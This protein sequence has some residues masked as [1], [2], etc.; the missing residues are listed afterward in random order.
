MATQIKVFSPEHDSRL[1]PNLHAISARPRPDFPFAPRAYKCR[2][3]SAVFFGNSQCLA[4]NSTLGFDPY[5][6][7]LYALERGSSAGLWTIA[8][9]TDEKDYY[10]CAN[11]NTPASCNWLISQTSMVGNP[12]QLCVACRLSRTIPDLSI[13]GNAAL[14]GRIEMAKRRLVSSLLALGLPVASSVDEDSRRGLAFDLL[15]SLPESPHVMTGYANGLIT[16]NIEEA[17]DASRE[18][19]RQQMR[20]PYRTLLGHLRHEVGHYY[21]ERLVAGTP[22]LD[23]FRQL[24]GDERQNYASA[25]RRNYAEGP[26]S[27]WPQHYVS[28]YASTH[29]WEDWAETWAHYLHMSDTLGTALSL[30]IDTS[31]L[32]PDITPFTRE[33]LFRPQAA[34]AAQFLSFLNAWMGLTTVLN[35][36]SRSMGQPDFYPFAI[37][38]KAVRKLHFIHLV[39]SGFSQGSRERLSIGIA[40]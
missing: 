31:R 13:P 17:D 20:E 22:L 34:G 27:D 7:S 38:L 5:R 16:I 1:R 8:G 36:L 39:T 32:V 33:E 14:W 37:P 21:W 30:G 6:G 25:L 23:D 2:C 12:R 19:V 10:R 11:L 40:A 24:F 3:G 29:P 18:R 26:P 28:P 4:C 15:R 35:K 9:D